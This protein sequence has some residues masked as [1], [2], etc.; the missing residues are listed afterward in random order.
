[1]LSWS[2]LFL[3]INWHACCVFPVSVT[4]LPWPLALILILLALVPTCCT[5]QDYKQELEILQASVL[6]GKQGELGEQEPIPTAG[7]S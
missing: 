5:M 3:R 1:M 2:L 4:Y 7:N 6:Q